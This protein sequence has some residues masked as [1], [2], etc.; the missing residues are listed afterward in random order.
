MA[1][2]SIGYNFHLQLLN[3]PFRLSRSASLR[4]VLQLRQQ[5]LHPVPHQGLTLRIALEVKVLLILACFLRVYSQDPRGMMCELQI[6]TVLGT[7]WSNRHQVSVLQSCAKPTAHPAVTPD[8]LA[9]VSFDR[10]LRQGSPF[11]HVTTM[12]VKINVRWP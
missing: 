8:S 4:R 1:P 5:L 6:A 3:F 2:K 11:A 7:F 10:L 9:S 12:P